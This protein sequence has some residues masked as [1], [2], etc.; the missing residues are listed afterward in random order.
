MNVYYLKVIPLVLAVLN[1]LKP[2]YIDRVSLFFKTIALLCPQR[3][4]THSLWSLLKDS[5][6]WA[7]CTQTNISQAGHPPGKQVPNPL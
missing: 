2:R 5:V 7:I 6:Y 3:F 1:R 4:A